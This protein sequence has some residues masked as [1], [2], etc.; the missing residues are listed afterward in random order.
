[1]F[2]PEVLAGNI[3]KYRIRKGL[4]QPELAEK[5]FVSSQAISKW[6]F[7]ERT[8]SVKSV[9]AVRVSGDIGG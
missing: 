2:R 6:E 5:L 8:G 9:E 7:A 1:M 3:K 4:T